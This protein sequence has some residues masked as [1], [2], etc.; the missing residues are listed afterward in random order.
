LVNLSVVAVEVFVRGRA[1]VE[2]EASVEAAAEENG[3]E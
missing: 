3:I 1:A 2:E